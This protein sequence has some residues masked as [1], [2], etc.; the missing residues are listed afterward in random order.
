MVLE[1]KNAVITGAGK[2]IGRAIAILF[3]GEGARVMVSDVDDEASASVIAEINQKGGTALSNHCDVMNFNETC[4]LAAS[5]L[6]AWGAVDILVNNAGGAFVAGKQVPFDEYTEE[7]INKTIGVNLMGVIYCS[8]AFAGNMKE[9][10]KGKII[11]MS[12]IGGIQGTRGGLY[13]TAKGGI[14]TFTKSLAMELAEFG[15]TV[16][17]ISPGAIATRAGPASLPTRLGRS[18]A[19]EEVAGLAL[20]LASAQADFITGSNYTIDGGRSC[21]S[22][23]D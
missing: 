13:S 12:S 4:N 7:A 6:N 20:F 21:G 14:I 5:A 9:R 2:G 17:C 22:M 15:I 1:G 16:N 18:G 3:A 11:N 10:R 19:P 8:R 23:G